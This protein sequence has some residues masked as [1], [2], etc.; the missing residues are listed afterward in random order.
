MGDDAAIWALTADNP[1]NDI[2]RPPE[3]LA[4]I[5]AVHG[6]QAVVNIFPALPNSAAVEVGRV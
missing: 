2:M 4:R 5:K 1:R 3:D 6:A